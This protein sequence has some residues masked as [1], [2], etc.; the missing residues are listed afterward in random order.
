MGLRRVKPLMDAKSYGL[1]IYQW[2]I[3]WGM[4]C[5]TNWEW[6]Q[7]RQFWVDSWGHPARRCVSDQ[8]VKVNWNK[9][10]RELQG[11]QL[12]DQWDF[13][14]YHPIEAIDYYRDDCIVHTP[15][16]VAIPA[17]L[18]VFI[19]QFTVDDSQLTII[20]H[21][22][23]SSATTVDQGGVMSWGGFRSMHIVNG[24]WNRD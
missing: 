11:Y 19:F 17:M 4:S 13:I 9:F 12:R 6:W 1:E 8:L 24:S 20:G 18:N 7:Q 22:P 10:T 23:R 2:Q 14:S 16:K 3:Q 5:P 15:R 21:F